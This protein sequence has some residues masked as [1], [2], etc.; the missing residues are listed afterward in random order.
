MLGDARHR[1]RGTQLTLFDRIETVSEKA[2]NLMYR[3]VSVE[4]AI[5]AENAQ[6]SSNPLCNSS[7]KTWRPLKDNQAPARPENPSG[8]SNDL[9]PIACRDMV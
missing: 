4:I 7:V 2:P 5:F 9:G 6:P 8:F 3:A 1:E